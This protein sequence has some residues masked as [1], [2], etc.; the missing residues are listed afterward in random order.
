MDMSLGKLRER[1]K[2]R[3]AWWA[4]VHRVQ[5]VQYNVATEQQQQRKVD[6]KN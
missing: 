3:E 6:Q 1:I 5:G 4:A 2:D